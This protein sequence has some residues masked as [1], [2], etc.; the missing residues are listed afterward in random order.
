MHDEGECAPIHIL[1]FLLKTLFK[2]NFSEK[3]KTNTIIS[4][5]LQAQVS[6]GVRRLIKSK[7]TGAQVQ[8]CTPWKT[9]Y[10]SCQIS[11]DIVKITGMCLYC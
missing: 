10:P 6:I 4:L 1:L 2:Q 11:P 3:A 5:K 7:S 8:Q 9:L